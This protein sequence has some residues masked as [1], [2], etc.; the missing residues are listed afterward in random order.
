MEREE[1]CLQGLRIW[2]EDIGLDGRIILTWWDIEITSNFA[3]NG[4]RRDM[5][6]GSE[7]MSHFEDIGLDGRII[8]KWIIKK[9]DGKI[10]I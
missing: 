4:E 6:T 8:L 2:F 9:W 3:P 1:I 10:W 7:D 5:L